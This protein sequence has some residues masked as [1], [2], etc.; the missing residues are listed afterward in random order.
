MTPIMLQG[1]SEISFL[2][3]SCDPARIKPLLPPTLL[4]DTFDEKGWISLTPFL[5]TGLRPPFVPATLGIDFPEMNLRTY[6]IGPKGPGIWFFS[7][8]AGRL[9]PVL[10]AR[11]TFGLP[12][13]WSK[14]AIDIGESENVHTSHRHNGRAHALVRIQKGP[15]IFVQSPL[16]VFLTARFRLYS[17]WAHRLMSAEVEHPQWKLR[18]VR[19]LE[20]NENVRRAMSVEFPSKDFVAHHSIGVATKVG[21]PKPA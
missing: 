5:L 9:L 2:H 16:D 10:G 8:D 21:M 14:M 4:I 15:D 7:L 19:V 12:Y 20:L 17:I 13:F 11:A 6:V 3:W 1:W 18:Q